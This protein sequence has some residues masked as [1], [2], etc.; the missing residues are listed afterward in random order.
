MK[1]RT[2]FLG[3]PIHWL[4]WPVIAGLYIGMDSVHLHVTRFNAFA[5]VLLGAA[6]AVVAWLRLTTREDEQVTREPIPE[7]PGAGG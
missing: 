4:P 6:I 1:L 2:V 7:E 5:F 3:K